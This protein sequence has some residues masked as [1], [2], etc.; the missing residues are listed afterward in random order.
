MS[1]VGKAGGPDNKQPQLF[2]VAHLPILERYG[3]RRGKQLLAI[4]AFGQMAAPLV[5]WAYAK[6][7]VR[8]DFTITVAG[9]DSIYPDLHE[10]V[11]ERMPESDRKALIAS[12]VTHRK[13]GKVYDEEGPS[14]ARETAS[15]R[16]RYDGTRRQKV[17]VHGHKVEVFI[18]REEFPGRTSLPENW[19]QMMEKI[20]FLSSSP[21]GRDAIVE[22]ISELVR[23]KH[24]VPRPPALFMPSR[25]GNGWTRRDDL[26][27]RTLESVVLKEGQ[28]E[29]LT[30]DL[31]AFLAAEDEYTRMSQ[32]WHRGYLL[33]G[34][35]GTGKTSAAR[36]IANHFGLP[37]YYLPLGDIDSDTDLMSFVGQIEPRSVLLIEDADAF[38]TTTDREEMDKKVSI[39]GMLNALDGIFTPHG[40]IMVMTTNN[41]DKLDPALIR[42]GR[43]DVDEEFTVLDRQQA[44][45]LARLFGMEG[46]LLPFID[47]SP[48]E[49]IRAI[50]ET[51]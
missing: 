12:T 50:R 16:L 49:M 7:R 37:T 19:R 21:A 26:P 18:E 25:Y 11:L 22:M 8:E 23:A 9:E 42:A 31:A 39:A 46:N 38:H 29:R 35:P 10:W 5:K 24:D 28:L 14:V 48:S 3:G 36:A 13:E 40:L 45:E 4:L 47:Q 20:T 41:R 30:S 1:G 34:A 2:N 6:A 51:K 33:H 44:G 17:T 27:A 15:V 43:V 32:P